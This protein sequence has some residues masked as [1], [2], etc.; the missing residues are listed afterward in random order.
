LTRLG[1]LANMSKLMRF[2]HMDTCFLVDVVKSSASITNQPFF[3][4]TY[5]RACVLKS[6][7][8]FNEPSL[9][10]RNGYMN[11]TTKFS[12]DFQNAFQL[13]TA[14]Q[15]SRPF[16]FRGYHLYITIQKLNNQNGNPKLDVALCLDQ[17]KSCIPASQSI[18]LKH[19]SK[20]KLRNV[21]SHQY[22]TVMT[23]NITAYADCMAVLVSLEWSQVENNWLSSEEGMSMELKIKLRNQGMC[24]ICRT[25]SSHLCG[26]C[27]NMYYCSKDCQKQHWPDHKKECKAP[28][29]LL[30]DR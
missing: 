23:N 4:E 25:I 21:N 30:H 8:V 3:Q 1:D 22:E 13:D 14:P 26:Q 24:K 7:K 18:V 28:G 17:E 6:Q 20:L 16:F 29:E 9:L 5:N 11:A 19:R 10:P 12:C 27:R 15:K 2:A